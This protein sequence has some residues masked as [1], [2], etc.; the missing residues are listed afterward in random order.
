MPILRPLWAEFPE[1]ISTF[2]EQDAFLLGDAILVKPVTKEGVVS[3]EVNF[4]G[5]SDQLWY[6][7]ET[8]QVYTA[9]QKATIST[10]L[11]RIAVLQRGGTIVPR[12]NRLRRSSTQMFNDPYTLNIALD[13][14]GSA[15]GKLYIDDGDTFDYRSGSYIYRALNISK[16]ENM[17]ILKSSVLGNGKMYVRNK[18]ER[19]VIA[20]ISKPS[21]IYSR[22][23]ESEDLVPLY[24]EYNDSIRVLTVKNPDVIASA[25]WSVEFHF[26][27]T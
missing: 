16:F 26:G 13:S 9:G 25:N 8:Y 18:I 5:N 21:K 3:T 22:S 17:M 11:E 27:Q 20:G 15:H 14:S 6:D 19:V 4:P 7:T 10:P 24:F 2:T 12:K 1:D 23:K